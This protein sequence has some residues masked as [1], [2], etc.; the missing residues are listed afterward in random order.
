MNSLWITSCGFMTAR[1]NCFSSTPYV[2]SPHAC[3]VPEES[4]GW[5]ERQGAEKKETTGRTNSNNPFLSVYSCC[6]ITHKLLTWKPIRCF[7]PLPH[8]LLLP[9]QW[10]ASCQIGRLIGCSSSNMN[11]CSA[12]ALRPRCLRIYLSIWFRDVLYACIRGSSFSCRRSLSN[13]S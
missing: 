6:M 8:I 11:D 4:E 12:C 9:Q 1:H 7:L 3:Q 10:A 2:L 13:S 5:R